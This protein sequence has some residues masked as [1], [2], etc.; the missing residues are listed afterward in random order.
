M[1]KERT[2]AIGI[3][4][5]CAVLSCSRLASGEESFTTLDLSYNNTFST[6]FSLKLNDANDTVYVKQDF[7]NG[8]GLQPRSYYAIVHD[9]VKRLLISQAE[10]VLLLHPDSLYDEGLQDG[11]EYK[12]CIVGSEANS[13]VRVHTLNL[14]QNAKLFAEHLI[15]FKDRLTYHKLEREIHY[16]SDDILS[17][18]IKW[19]SVSFLPP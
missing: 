2:W 15:D 3:V 9:D 17:K 18:P 7:T 4:L 5:I 14:P 16:A 6:A 8:H 13:C 11:E 1:R 19:D 10:S 12:I